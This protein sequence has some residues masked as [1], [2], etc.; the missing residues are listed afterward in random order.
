ML[1]LNLSTM[2]RLTSLSVL[3]AA[4]LA[5][6]FAAA[7]ACISAASASR[8]ST[9]ATSAAVTLAGTTA[10]LSLGFTLLFLGGL[11]GLP[12]LGLT[13]LRDVFLLVFEL[14]FESD[15]ELLGVFIPEL[16]HLC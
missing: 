7:L 14:P 5:A 3:S 12:D 8:A 15:D 6:A 13:V 16:N 11:P 2:K 4:A 10:A 9:S 1:G